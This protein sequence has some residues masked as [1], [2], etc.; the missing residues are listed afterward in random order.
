MHLSYRKSLR[1]ALWIMN[2]RLQRLGPGR[3]FKALQARKGEMRRPKEK[4]D[5]FKFTPWW[6]NPG[7]PNPCEWLFAEAVCSTLIACETVYK[8]QREF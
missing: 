3:L 6:M 8:N 2:L 1:A 5:S 4:G 7:V